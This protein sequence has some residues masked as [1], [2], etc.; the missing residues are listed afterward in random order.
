MKAQVQALPNVVK[1]IVVPGYNHFDFLVGR[2]TRDA[3]Y[4]PIIEDLKQYDL[5]LE[6]SSSQ[7]DEM[8]DFTEMS[9]QLKDNLYKPIIED[10]QQQK[11]S[12]H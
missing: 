3:L 5:N 2:N 12:N 7:E 9:E 8:Q 1:S 6:M 4:N 11:S 10:W